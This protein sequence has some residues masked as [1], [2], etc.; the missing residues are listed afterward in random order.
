MEERSPY[1]KFAEMMLDKDSVY[2][3]LIL[4]NMINPSQA[5]LLV[6][7]PGTVADLKEKTGQNEAD[8]EG[9]LKDMFRKG[10]TFKKEKPGQPIFWRGPMHLV[11]FHDAAIVWPEASQEFYDLWAV[12]MEKEWPKIAPQLAKFLPKPFT[13]VI[14]VGASLDAGKAQILTYENMIDIVNGAKKIA[15]TKCTCRLT[16]RK[17]ENPIEVCL[18]IN[19][20]AEYTIE[21]GSGREITTE[22]AH[23]I[24]RECAEAGLIHVTMNKSGIGHFICNCCGCCCEAFTLLISDG[25]ALCDPSRFRPELAPDLCTGCGLCEERCYFKAISLSGDERP[26]VTFDRC[27]GCGQCAIGCPAGAITMVEEREPG[28]IPA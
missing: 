20:G 1:R 3:P 24:I 19:N 28:F 16:M 17:C 4:K 6:S 5:E 15:V 10:L 7:L 13:R 23:R 26:T 12:Y 18:Q 14:P 2:I 27:M 25:V 11:Q 21:R 22:E 8:I 9:N